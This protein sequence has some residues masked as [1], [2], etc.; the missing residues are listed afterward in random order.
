[1]EQTARNYIQLLTELIQKQIVILGPEIT[2]ARVRKVQGVIVAD[3][4]TVTDITGDP[5][6]ITQQVIDQ[7]VQLSGDIVRQTMAPLIEASQQDTLATPPPPPVTPALEPV[8]PTPEPVSE[9]PTEPTVVLAKPEPVTP[10]MPEPTPPVEPSVLEPKAEPVAEPTT[11]PATPETITDVLK[12]PPLVEVEPQSNN[13]MFG[14]TVVTD[15]PAEEPPA[16]PVAAPEPTPVPTPEPVVPTPMID[17]APPPHV[18]Q[19]AVVAPPPPPVEQPTTPPTT[20]PDMQ[21][22]INEALKQT[23]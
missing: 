4:G 22:I 13:P 16:V 21:H 18:E 6:L 8:A 1:M 15:Q 14:Q 11:P 17:V 2:L 3:D 10:A 7:F 12:A 19:P 23:Q 9:Q 20:D 5:Q